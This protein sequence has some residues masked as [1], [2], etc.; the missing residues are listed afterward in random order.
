[1]VSTTAKENG[2][3]SS[4]AQNLPPG[5]YRLIGWDLDTSG[6]RLFDEICQIAAY[7]PAVSFSQ[8]VMPFCNLDPISRR[9][10]N[11]RIVTVGRFRMLK[12]SKSGKVLKTKS[13]ISALTDFI[14]WLENMKGDSVD[15][16][17]LI[18]HELRKVAAPLLLVALQKYNL[19]E[20]FSAVVKGF[21]NGYEIAAEKCAKTVHSFSLRTL[22]R[23]LLDKEE[24][25]DN[26]TDR[27]RLAFQVIQ[28]LCAGEDRPE[29][30]QGSGDAIDAANRGLVDAVRPSTQTVAKEELDLAG[31][32]V[33][34]ERQK[35]LRPIFGA[36][37]GINKQ[38][39]Q[40]AVNLRR[41]LVEAGIDYAML[42]AAYGKDGKESIAELLSSKVPNT[43]Q[44]EADELKE[45]LIHHFD[46]ESE[47]KDENKVKVNKENKAGAGD[48]S[49]SS[50][51]DTTTSSPVK[52]PSSSGDTNTNTNNSPQSNTTSRKR[53]VSAGPAV[54]SSP[55]STA[56]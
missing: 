8:Y 12:D 15:G 44:K 18:S 23:V 55:E 22:S 39:R 31:L 30:S 27:A 35:S 33:V 25:L 36:L 7:T 20:R 3:Q 46:P 19:L 4:D 48:A 34:L 21:A 41:I 14:Q 40:R 49:G 54:T 42:K 45:L 13:E 10:H 51:P 50:T 28:H 26:A 2:V 29:N 43:K 52:A 32:K 16:V 5:D 1:M 47:P 37:L 11:I 17:I 9:R 38:E 24:E 53:S 6:R 56:S